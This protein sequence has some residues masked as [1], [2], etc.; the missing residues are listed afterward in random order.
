MADAEKEKAPEKAPEKKS[1]LGLI[2]GIFV[3]SLMLIGGSVAGA[4]FVPK[5]LGTTAQASPGEEPAAGAVEGAKGDAEKGGDDE[6]PEP[7]QAKPQETIVSHELKAVIVD[8]RDEDG[9]VRHL[10]V[11]LV[12]EL[13]EDVTVDDFKLVVP[14]GREAAVSYL[15]TLSFEEIS[16]PK[17][18][19]EIKNELATRVTKAVGTS[20]V[21]QILVV[22]FVA[23]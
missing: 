3:G 10:K 11:G 21:H 4:L 16:D 22:D 9:R 13:R 19:T 23:Q 7:E 12:A 1:K 17:M 2:L 8:L 18:Y 6:Q 15:R 5:L 14:R 20:R